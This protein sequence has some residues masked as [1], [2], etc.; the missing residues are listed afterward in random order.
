MSEQDKRNKRNLGR[1][2][3]PGGNPIIKTIR[4]YLIWRREWIAGMTRRQRIRHRLFQGLV[5]CS[6]CVIVVLLGISSWVRM[7]NIPAATPP[8][9]GQTGAGSASFEGAEVPDIALSGRQEGVYTFL[10]AGQDTDSGNTDT[11]ILVTYDTVNQTVHCMNIPRDTM[12]NVKWSVKKINSVYYANRGSDKETQV[13][14]GMAALGRHVSKLTGIVPDFYVFLQWQAVGELVD[15]LGGIT[16][17]VPFDMKYDD[18]Y[19]DL[20][21]DQEAGVRVLSG[22]DAMQVVRW[23]QNNDRS[24]SAMGDIGRI[25]IQQDFLK[26]VAKECLQLK[27]LLKAPALMQIFIDNVETDLSIGNLLAFAQL[28]MGMDADEDVTFCTMPYTGARYRG[29]DY[30][31]VNQNEM[32]EL[33]NAGFNP[34]LRDIAASDLQ[35]MYTNSNG[36]L[37]VTNAALVD[38]SAGIASAAPST[39]PPSVTTPSGGAGSNTEDEDEAPDSSQTEGGGGEEPDSGGETGNGDQGPGESASETGSQTE[40]GNPAQAQGSSAAQTQDPGGSQSKAAAQSA[41][42]SQESAVPSPMG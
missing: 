13:E 6:L 2:A 16:F 36:S 31:V 4:E 8:D 18:P 33:I 40:S 14:N 30:V 38:G 24:H 15:A 23:R 28:A 42:S 10:V 35:L 3:E 27:T 1:R 11:I 26:A 39:P 22:E 25:Q 19:Q 5:I 41:G 9:P 29:G 34:Y 37:G 32:L 12:V 17:E 21:I 7:P 20:H